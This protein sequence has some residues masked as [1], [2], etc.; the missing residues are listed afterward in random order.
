M[1][2]RTCPW[3]RRAVSA[4]VC[5]HQQST[6][7][8]SSRMMSI[9]AT[10]QPNMIHHV[11]PVVANK[12]NKYAFSSKPEEVPPQS[13]TAAATE[14]S[15]TPP[16]AEQDP[17]PLS[18]EEVLEAQIK[19]LK[20]QLLRGLAEQENTR[21]IAKRDVESARNFAVSSFAKSLLDTSDNLSRAL[22]SIP[23]E[24]LDSVPE[25]KTLFEG[26]QMTDTN[27][28]KAFEKHG[29]SKFG[30]VGE[31]FDPNRHEA[32]Y[33]YPDPTKEPGTLGQIMKTG[34]TLN[35]RVIRPAEVGVI[36]KS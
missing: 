15:T 30:K 3:I 4:A 31:V 2:T 33:E 26:I 35:G 13:E 20:D 21:R 29:L 6:A 1:S 32:L 34:F 9:Y 16:D 23:S 11:R 10:N 19:D 14:E 5:N 28:T 8:V 17:E 36:K 27:L 12:L 7:K 18:R 24:K 25:L 22:E